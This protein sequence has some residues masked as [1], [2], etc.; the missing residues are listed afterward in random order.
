MTRNGGPQFGACLILSEQ[1]RGAHADEVKQKHAQ[2]RTTHWRQC[3]S[4]SQRSCRL[5]QNRRQPSKVRGNLETGG[6]QKGYPKGP[7][8]EKFQDLEIFKRA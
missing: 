2:D 7:N 8:L 5:S 1:H 3:R 4:L 6:S